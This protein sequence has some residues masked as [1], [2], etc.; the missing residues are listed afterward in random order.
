M[1]RARPGGYLLALLFS[2]LFATLLSLGLAQWLRRALPY[3]AAFDVIS[4]GLN[5]A[6]CSIVVLLWPLVFKYFNAYDTNHILYISQELQSVLIGVAV[7][8]LVVAG[9]LFLSYRGL[10]R[11]LFLY[12]AILDALTVVVGRLLMR[13]IFKATGASRIAEQRILLVGAGEVGTQLA[14]L[15][16]ARSWMGLRVVGFLDDDPAKLGRQVSG[17]TVLGPLDQVTQWVRQSSADEVIITLPMYAHQKLTQLA[18]ALAEMPVNLRVV[19]D[20]LPLAYLRTTVGVLGD[21]PLIT[22]KEPALDDSALFFK[23]I[24]DLVVA[25]LGVLI[26]WPILLLIALGIKLDS[27]GPIV[28]RQQRIGWHG[29]TFTILKFRTMYVGAEKR[30]EV[31]VDQ[32]ADGKRFLRKERADPRVTPIGRF[33]RRWSLDELLQLFNVLKGEM[34]MVGPRPEL[35]MLVHDYEPWQWKRFSVPP[36]LTGWWQVT[37]RADAPS[38]LHVESDMYY[39]RNYSIFLDLQI[40]LR[41][42]GAVLHGKGAY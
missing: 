10:S 38:S 12:F 2:D 13:L 34:S 29:K 9:T 23:R 39:I 41:T 37:A 26:V 27:P 32:T 15:L 33:L 18:W 35:P 1:K 40:L 3:G 11:L 31:I 5:L 7:S 25:G 28:F 8:T 21:M 22:L 30:I 19:P 20:L 42:V 14:E 24:M 6:I 4:G 16:A 17:V 36:G